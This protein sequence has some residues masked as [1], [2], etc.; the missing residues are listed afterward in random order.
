MIRD[1][2]IAA[3]LTAACAIVGCSAAETTR[4]P[5]DAGADVLTCTTWC[6]DDEGDLTWCSEPCPSDGGA[7]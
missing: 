7:E 3:A 5:A 2:I 6:Y 4:D 1:T